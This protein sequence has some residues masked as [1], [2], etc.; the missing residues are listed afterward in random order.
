MTARHSI[1]AEA[2]VDIMNAHTAIDD[3]LVQS[4]GSWM[5]PTQLNYGKMLVT[6]VEDRFNFQTRGSALIV[7]MTAG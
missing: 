4:V 3:T 1:A 5:I 7:L 2:S 6:D